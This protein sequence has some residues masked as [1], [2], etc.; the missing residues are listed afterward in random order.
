QN[1]PARAFGKQA[2]PEGKV[3]LDVVIEVV[4]D[5]SAIVAPGVAAKELVAA[6]SRQHYLDELRGEAGGGKVG[7]KLADARLFQVPGELGQDALHIAGLQHHLIMLGLEEIGHVLRGTALVE[8]HLYAG[9]G[10][11]VEAD[12]ERADPWQLA[13]GES[14]DRTGVH[15]ARQVGA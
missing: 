9:G 6:G 11:Q 15:A 14:G 4:V 5:D 3:L 2:L 1:L 12:R 8:A 10:V 13:S 7:G